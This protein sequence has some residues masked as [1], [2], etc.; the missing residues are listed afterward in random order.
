VAFGV[1][2]DFSEGYRVEAVVELAVSAGLSRCRTGRPGEVGRGCAAVGGGEAVPGW[3]PVFLRASLICSVHS[4]I[5][6][7]RLAS[8]SRRRVSSARTPVSPSSNRARPRPTSLT[9]VRTVGHRSLVAVADCRAVQ[10]APWTR[11]TRRVRRSS[12]RSR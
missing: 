1:T 3:V 5:S 7:S 4:A 9:A 10:L 11:S 8:R 12:R 2:T 6:V